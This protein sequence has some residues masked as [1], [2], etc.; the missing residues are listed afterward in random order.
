MI[1]ISFITIL[2]DG[3][4]VYFSNI[5]FGQLNIFYPMLT[6]SLIPFFDRRKIKKYYQ[7]C[8]IIGFIYDLFYS[9]IFLFNAMLFLLLGFVDLNILKR[10]KN[11]LFWYIVIV[12]VNI[13]LYD[14]INFLFVIMSNYQLINLDALLYKI[15]HSLLLNIM[16][17]FVYFILF[18]RKAY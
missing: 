4:I 6:I 12:V 2:L 7:N 16:S 1:I 13:I 9:N 15:L 14:T 17:C 5:S 3:I 18:K 10:M 11:N 8:F